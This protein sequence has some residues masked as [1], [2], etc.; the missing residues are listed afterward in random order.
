MKW[1]SEYTWREGVHRISKIQGVIKVSWNK[2]HTKDPQMLGT[3][4]KISVASVTWS[5]TFLHLC[6]SKDIKNPWRTHYNILNTLWMGDADLHIYITTVQDGWCTSAFLTRTW[7][8]CTIHFNYAIHAAFLWMVLLTDVY[9]NMTS[10]RS[11]DP[12]L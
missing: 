1:N 2:F 12:C 11:N 4:I 7:F 6:I 5:M 8:P 9:R 10:L 3:T